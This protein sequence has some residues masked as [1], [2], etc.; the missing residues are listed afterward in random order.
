MK[1][2]DKTFIFS[3]CHFHSQKKIAYF[4]YAIGSIKFEEIIEFGNKKT[5]LSEKKIRAINKILPLLHLAVG[6]SYYKAFICPKIK[7]KSFRISAKVADFFNTFYFKGLGEFAYQNKVDLRFLKT[8]FTK[9]EQSEKSKP[10]KLVLSNKV[11]IPLGGGKDSIVALDIIKSEGTPVIGFSVGSFKEPKEIA[12]IANI[13]FFEIKRKIDPKLF[14]LNEEGVFNGHVPVVGILSFIAV[15]AAIIFD[16]DTIVFANEKSSSAGNTIYFGEEINHQWSKSFEFENNFRDLL[17]DFTG[18][19]ISYFSILRPFSEIEIANKFSK[20]KKFHKTFVSCNKNYQIKERSQNKWCGNCDKCRF[21]FLA[22]ACNLKKDRL[23]DIF[24]GKNLL[25]DKTQVEGFRELVGI[26]GHKPFECVGEVEESR[27]L[28]SCLAKEKEWKDDSVIKKI[29][30]QIKPS[31][32]NKHQLVETINEEDLWK[33][34][35]T[36]FKNKI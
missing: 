6:I 36:I 30:N 17:R 20:L 5:K 1:N 8:L 9:D 32:N 34:I 25:N 29:N 14:D 10:E 33:N 12:K 18:E 16:F 24:S 23:I 22:L 35:P 27:Q 15:I 31:L 11:G 21:V 4:R 13:P 26:Q 3:S 7:I 2:Q 19:S 28:F